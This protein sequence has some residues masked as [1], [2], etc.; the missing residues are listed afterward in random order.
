[1]KEWKVKVLKVRVLGLA[2]LLLGV[3]G[4]QS[5]RVVPLV[6]TAP[7][8]ILS[9]EVAGDSLEVVVRYSGGCED[10]TWRLEK[11]A[12]MMKSLPPKQPILLIHGSHGD[13][14]RALIVDTLHLELKPLRAG[15]IGVTLFLLETW[16]PELIYENR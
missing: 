3:L 2:A 8:T 1:M 15:P 9:A 5:T 16:K 14:C 7:F 13:M 11:S 6:E 4:C 12:P 10:H